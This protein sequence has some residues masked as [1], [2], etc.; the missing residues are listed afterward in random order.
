MKPSEL[1]IEPTGES[2]G[3]RDCSG[4]HSKTVWGFVHRRQAETIAA[5]FVQW[6]V[7]GS[8]ADHPA[9]IDLVYGRWGDGASPNDRRAISLVHFE[10]DGVPGIM[11][12]D[13]KK[14]S[15]ATSGLAG[16][17]MARDDVVG[18]DLATNVFAIVD[19]ILVQDKRLQ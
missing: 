18:T 2:G 11:V 9:N 1:E 7:G 13:A 6:T 8:L 16:E 19:A 15:V 10:D 12:I 4:N 14:R 5:Y 3:Y 17:A